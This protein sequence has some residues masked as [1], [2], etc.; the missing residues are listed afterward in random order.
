MGV[1]GLF[2]WLLRR[3]PVACWTSSRIEATGTQSLFV[4]LNSTLHHGA[5]QSQG[6][7]Q[8][9]ATAVDD[10]V[11]LIQPSQLL[12]LAID[13]V[14]PR[15][16]ERLQRERRE[17][18]ASAPIS[19]FNSYSIT[20]GT[21]WMH[22]VEAYLCEF[23]EHKRKSDSNWQNLSVVF[24]GCQDPGE[25]EQKIMEYLRTR[26][27]EGGHHCIWSNDADSVLLS[28]TTRVPNIT[29]ISER[30]KGGISTYTVFN[31]DM[32]REQMVSRYSSLLAEPSEELPCHVKVDRLYGLVD[33]L[34]FMTLFAGNDF[35]PA[36][37]FVMEWL[38]E[39][40]FIDNLL[41]MYG[42]L[43][44]KHQC[45]HNRGQINPKAFR[46]LLKVFV[47]EGEERSFRK[48]VGVTA[49]GSQ[50]TALRIRRM[51]WEIQRE[52]AKGGDMENGD[53]SVSTSI[54]NGCDVHAAKRKK[55]KAAQTKG[56]V[57]YVWTGP[58]SALASM[59]TTDIALLAG[60]APLP[61]SATLGFLSVDP[62][63][64]GSLLVLDGQPLLSP[65]LL[66][67]FNLMTNLAESPGTLEVLGTISS[68]KLKWLQSLAK[69]LQLE[70]TVR[71]S[72]DP[73]FASECKKWKR[74]RYQPTGSPKDP[75]AMSA[76]IVVGDL[77]LCSPTYII[78][79]RAKKD[80]TPTD[81]MFQTVAVVGEDNWDMLY[82]DA[83]TERRR[84]AEL[85]EWRQGFY[86]RH[87]QQKGPQFIRHLCAYYADA[88]GWTTMYYFA[89]DV[90]SWEFAWPDDIASSRDGV[91]P[92]ASDLLEFLD[93]N[94]SDWQYLPV[95]DQ[96]A[97]LAREH[98][99]SIMPRPSWPLV[100]TEEERRLAH[101]LHDNKY[102]E[103]TRQEVHSRLSAEY[104]PVVRVWL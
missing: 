78:S 87:Y 14:P 48:H 49:L 39:P 17:R 41:A 20:P 9:I 45:L 30:P 15:M 32:L 5:R 68:N 3:F 74:K 36:V 51:E 99:L 50:L 69:V 88:L 86:R 98:M 65:I 82:G 55:G 100:L 77:D 31:I 33:D 102:S 95:S 25:G 61:P 10:L 27:F 2:R 75:G 21:S 43:P 8:A 42:H 90:S 52:K 16:K 54:A 73:K 46:E 81:G 1:P 67:S 93:P 97:P 35:L 85:A 44:A 101:L 12:Y 84:D 28:L 24:S 34:V 13:G 11:N 6:D 76:T 62:S 38:N 104:V 7:F 19:S 83:R 92:L 57:P 23:I 64:N 66:S 70:C 59:Q 40:D 91:A 56:M 4:D 58:A 72:S 89:G 18:L 47:V 26:G 71:T 63:S 94:M 79:L 96:A 22:R 29:M 53:V 60:S 80:R 37:S 103:I